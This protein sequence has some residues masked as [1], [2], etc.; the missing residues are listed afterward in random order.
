MHTL[1]HAK[2]IVYTKKSNIPDGGTGL[3]AKKHIT[4]DIP[5]VIYYGDK[6]TE[7][8]LYDLYIHDPNGYYEV[9]KYI[10]G[11]SNDY[12]IN[13]LVTKYKKEEN[14]NLLGVYVNDISSINCK[15]EEINEKVLR[16][17]AKTI[18]QCNVKTV[19]T[20]EYP[21]YV[22]IKRIKKNE[23]IYAH[24]GIGNWLSSIGFTPEEISD[25]NKKYDFNS[26]YL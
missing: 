24:Y 12:S 7:N 5:V 13:G 18:K 6:I 15:K 1:N 9:N 14:S 21:I 16:E 19:D 26:F 25:L 17:Y 23:E 22:A 8:Q 2:P 10:R 3:F 11:T 20:N 4:K